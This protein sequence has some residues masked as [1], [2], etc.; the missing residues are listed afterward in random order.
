MVHHSVYVPKKNYD[1]MNILL[2]YIYKKRLKLGTKSD[3]MD[4]KKSKLQVC[5][6]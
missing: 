5:K 3:I 1:N 2:Y 4:I 6:N